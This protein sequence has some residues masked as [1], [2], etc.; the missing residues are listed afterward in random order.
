[1]GE[2]GEL[3][4]GRGKGLLVESGTCALLY[5]VCGKS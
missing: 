1:M 4:G 2:V 5:F 3:H